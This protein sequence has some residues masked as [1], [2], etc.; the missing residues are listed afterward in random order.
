MGGGEVETRRSRITLLVAMIL[1]A[2]MTVRAQEAPVTPG[3]APA[4]QAQNPAPNT[5]P[6]AKLVVR[7]AMSGV[8]KAFSESGLKDA[9]TVAWVD[10]DAEGTVRHA[11]LSGTTGNAALDAEI[12]AWVLAAKLEP[13]TAGRGSI[14][15]SFKDESLDSPGKLSLDDIPEANV[16]NDFVKRP[17]MA[18]LQEVFGYSGESR[19]DTMVVMN[20]SEDGKVLDAMVTTPAPR[21]SARGKINAAVVAWAKQLKFKP[22]ITGFRKLPVSMK[23]D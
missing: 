11:E 2:T 23:T 1:M 5:V 9:R 21:I 8:M 20:V 7:P 22:G 6:R 14:P 19:Y 18:T 15:F 3:V 4:A 10:Y 13:G 16:H 17:S 12:M